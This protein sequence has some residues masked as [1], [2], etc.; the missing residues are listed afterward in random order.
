M[1]TARSV[2]FTVSGVA[3]SGAGILGIITAILIWSERYH[4]P[5]ASAILTLIAVGIIMVYSVANI[6]TGITALR[7]YN[8]R[9]LSSVIIRVPEICI[10]LAVI[11]LVLCFFNGI[12]VS[13]SILIIVSGIILPLLFIFAAV[14]K[15]EQ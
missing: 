15:S 7:K 8:R 9:I 2:L 13:H 4:A 10:G 14:H 6:I 11:S 1:G 12:I 3:V 5:G